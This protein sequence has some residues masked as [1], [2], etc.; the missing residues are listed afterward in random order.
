[1]KNYLKGI[2]SI[3]DIFPSNKYSNI[4]SGWETDKEAIKKDWKAVGD[5][6]KDII[7]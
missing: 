2:G 4:P 6:L 5:C 3:L 7:K 1:M